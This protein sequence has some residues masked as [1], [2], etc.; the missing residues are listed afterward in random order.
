MPQQK[1]PLLLV[2]DGPAMVFQA[3]FSRPPRLSANSGVDM[4]GAF[5]FL[6][7]FQMLLW[8]HQPTHVVLTLDP[9][10]PT[11]R[12]EL[13]PEYKA[14]R[15]PPD[16]EILQQFPMVRSIMQAHRVPVFEVEGFEADDLIG[17]LCA[18]AENEGINA[19]IVTNDTDQLQLVS[20]R[21]KLL[22]YRYSAWDGEY[23]TDVND[24]EAVRRRYG[25]LGPEYVADI[26]ALQGDS[27]DNI[28]GVPGV[29]RKSALAVLSNLGRL[30]QV[31]EKLDRVPYIEGLRGARRVRKLLEE[32]R[33]T[34]FE[35]RKLTT[36]VR[37]V[38]L[39]FNFANAE[40]GNHD[41]DEV[42]AVLEELEFGEV[43]SH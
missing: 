12:H 26:K 18:R 38:P 9:P 15:P 21:V 42:E 13:F 29:G 34:A 23:I 4:R 2:M 22:T 20:R 10:P 30:E 35:F 6:S 8:D 39:D 40:F 27:S 43:Y 17:T 37:D 14:H 7:A 5:G 28:P 33:Q 16:P 24:I 25:G 41:E 19:L 32:H 11:F 1:K 3:W 31:Y 36:I